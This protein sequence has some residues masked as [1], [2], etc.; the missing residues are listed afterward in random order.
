MRFRRRSDDSEA[1]GE[2]P[3]EGQGPRRPELGPHPRIP[4]RR[5]PS[6]RIRCPEPR[7]GRTCIRPAAGGR[8][9]AVQPEEPTAP[10]HGHRPQRQEEVE[11][12]TE[13]RVGGDH[14]ADQPGRHGREALVVQVLGR[15]QAEVGEPARQRQVPG[16]DA[17]R[18]KTGHLLVDGRVVEIRHGP[19]LGAQ[20][21]EAPDDGHG[22]DDRG[23]DAIPGRYAPGPDVGGLQVL[24]PG[25]R[26]GGGRRHGATEGAT[27]SGIT[28]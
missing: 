2:T 14:R 13:H 22:D 23:P 28:P 12:P 6:T 11:G 24:R 4:P 8:R 15:T 18:G 26:R 17:C 25:R 10:E 19:E 5:R 21:P 9:P 16:R 7:R 20:L 1:V 27:F 3:G